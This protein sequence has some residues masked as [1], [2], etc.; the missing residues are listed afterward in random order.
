MTNFWLPLRKGNKRIVNL[1]EPYTQATLGSLSG[2]TVNVNSLA[3]S[4][5]GTL[6][7]T[8]GG[9]PSRKLGEIKIWNTESQQEELSIEGHQGWIVSTE[10]SPDGRFL[11]TDQVT[12]AQQEYGMS[13]AGR[14]RRPLRSDQAVPLHSHSIQTKAHW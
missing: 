3:F 8:A 11:A 14:K 13:Q 1:W 7:A 2:H 9:D 5:D 10:F 4:P 6:L 12:L